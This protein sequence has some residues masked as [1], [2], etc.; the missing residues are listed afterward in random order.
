MLY[1][2]MRTEISISCVN[3]LLNVRSICNPNL[4]LQHLYP[5]VTLFFHVCTSIK[6]HENSNFIF[7]LKKLKCEYRFLNKIGLK[8]EVNSKIQRLYLINQRKLT[9]SVTHQISPYSIPKALSNTGSLFFQIKGSEC[10]AKK[11][12]KKNPLL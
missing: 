7:I 2:F 10:T 9:F 12:E 4:Y 1:Y 8:K 3:S 5:F 11:R 6:K